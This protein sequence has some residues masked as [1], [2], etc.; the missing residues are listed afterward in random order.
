MRKDKVFNNLGAAILAG[1]KNSRMSG[2][3]KAFIEINGIQVIARSIKILQGIF[4][5]IVI[6]TN[7]PEEFKLFVKEA[8]IITDIIRNVGPLG[9]MH[10]ALSATSKEGVFFAACDMPFLHND[11]ILRQLKDFAKTNCECLVPRIAG[12]VEP[13]HA[14]YKK[15]LKDK[16]NDYVKETADYSIRG[17]LKKI[18]VCYWDLE[19]SRLNRKMFRN[20][21]TKE[22]LEEVG[23]ALGCE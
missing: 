23:G 1:G 14:I 22:D 13:L 12:F 11:L 5:E 9:G 16:I 3:N 21:N 17:F 2:F 6:V 7:S 8:V 10:A 18:D 19:N 20:L 15:S 4:E